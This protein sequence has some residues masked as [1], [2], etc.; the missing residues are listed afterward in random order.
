MSKALVLKI[1]PK[2]LNHHSKRSITLRI[3]DI[4]M[5]KMHMYFARHLKNFL[6]RDIFHSIK[7]ILNI[8]KCIILEY[9]TLNTLTCNI[10]MEID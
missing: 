4:W 9:S 2:I 5:K 3:L 8:Q 7:H 1:K 10:L 6:K